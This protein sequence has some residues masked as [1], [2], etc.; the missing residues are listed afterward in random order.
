MAD[1]IVTLMRTDVQECD[2]NFR[3]EKCIICITEIRATDEIE[4]L[5]DERDKWQL[6]AADLGEHLENALYS[7]DWKTREYAIVAFGMF[8]RALPNWRK[9]RNPESTF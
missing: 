4:R 9:G 3:S 7:D 2:C 6:M 1:D 5:S 8:E